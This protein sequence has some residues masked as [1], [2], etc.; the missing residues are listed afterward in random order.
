MKLGVF[1][2]NYKQIDEIQ[3]MDIDSIEFKKGERNSAIYVKIVAQ[4]FTIVVIADAQYIKNAFMI[5]DIGALILN[6]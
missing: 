4:R 3:R 2:S 1:L 6:L 5:L